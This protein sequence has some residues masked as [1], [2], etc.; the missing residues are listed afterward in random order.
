MMKIHLVIPKMRMIPTTTTLPLPTTTWWWWINPRPLLHPN[1]QSWLPQLQIIQPVRVIGNHHPH[2]KCA[3]HPLQPNLLCLCRKGDPTLWTQ[4][5]SQLIV[6]HPS[7]FPRSTTRSAQVPLSLLVEGLFRSGDDKTFD[8][9][10]DI[11]INHYFSEVYS[12]GMEPHYDGLRKFH[13]SQ[14]QRSD[15]GQYQKKYRSDD[16]PKLM[17]SLKFLGLFWWRTITL[18]STRLTDGDVNLNLEQ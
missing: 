6:P 11:L 14:Y 10:K 18:Q 5:R 17:P 16:A 9:I 3:R 13:Q 7:G 4:L 2:P 8:E 15:D 1:H 12:C